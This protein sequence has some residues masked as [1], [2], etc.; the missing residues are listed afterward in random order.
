MA[1]IGFGLEVNKYAKQTGFD[2]FS[3]DLSD[4]LAET[5]K[6][7]WKY[8]PVSSAMRLYELNQSRDVDEPL[9]SF[10][11]LNK[12]YKN[13]GIF[14]E[15]D[16]KQST[17][18]VLVE[19]KKE[20]RDRQSIIQRGP[21][22]VV[23]TT[24]KFGTAMVASMADPI[25]LA[26]MFIPV[27]G[28]V[29]FASL[30]AKYGLTRARMMKGS[31]E[32]LVGIS[33]V[34]PLVYAAASAEQSDYG[35][36]DSFMAVSFGTILGGGLHV[37]AG[38]LKDVYTH[39][40]FKKR[41]RD[42]RKNLK[43]QGGED[44][45]FSLYREYY[46][47]NSRIMKELEE[48]D[49]DTRKLL[50]A[51]AIAD[52]G[53]EVP[54]NVKDYADLNPKLRHAQIDENIVEKARKKV[55]EESV[56]VNK[57]LT[58]VQNKINMLEKYF[59]PKRKISNIKYTPELKKL[60]KEKSKLL[61]REKELVEQFTSREKL[62]D[63]RITNKPQEITSPVTAKPRNIL[64]DKIVDGYN[65]DKAQSSIESRNLDQEILIAENNLV[66]KLEK[67][68]SLGLPESKETRASVKAL[69]DMK[70]K[71][72]D[73]ENAIMEGINCRIGK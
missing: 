25:N 55:N 68:R 65:K 48:I 3:T 36:M 23:A 31:I 64:V 41:I 14:F 7:A 58:E 47:E 19:R 39:R 49:P 26:M 43:S 8:N 16:E 51:K 33:A 42:S 71:S 60:K 30:V 46:P 44:P 52:L 57:K 6:D 70:S 59:D 54:V 63:Q 35:L 34:E 17:V 40:K 1:N 4:V 29:R 37:G 56:E 10:Q 73:Y 72:E 61:K 18:D 53:E 38:K 45:A 27:V 24:A 66:A 69:E 2:Q 67:Q 32:G 20:E 62:I 5:A 12:K 22:G 13:S 15:Q 50:L 21:T 28:Q 9:I 11:E